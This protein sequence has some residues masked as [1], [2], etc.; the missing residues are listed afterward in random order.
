M[1]HFS[2]L[3]INKAMI[4][5]PF[6]KKQVCDILSSQ[7]YI[8]IDY[9]WESK[10]NRM[11]PVHVLEGKDLK[12]IG[13]VFAVWGGKAMGVSLW[14]G[15]QRIRGINRRGR[16]EDRDGNLVRG[17]HDHIEEDGVVEPVT[18]TFG[19]IDEVIDYA[20]DKWNIKK[21]GSMA[22]SLWNYRRRPKT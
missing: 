15:R 14:L 8:E 10:K 16:H 5:F 13:L 1:Q 11:I 22:P 19:N 17:W 4:K 20:L 7:K 9:L 12:D 21:Y 2:K 18:E 3:A 6:T